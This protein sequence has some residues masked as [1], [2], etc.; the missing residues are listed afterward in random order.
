MDLGYFLSAGMRE[1]MAVFWAGKCL[2]SSCLFSLVIGEFVGS[3]QE[4][5]GI[6][7]LLE[8]CGLASGLPKL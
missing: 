3:G 8:G 1:E 6:I 7:F 5:S 4:V 2:C